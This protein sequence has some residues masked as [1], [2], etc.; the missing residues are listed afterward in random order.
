VGDGLPDEGGVR[1]LADMLGCRRRQVNEVRGNELG[2]HKLNFERFL[3]S[4]IKRASG[5]FSRDKRR[6]KWQASERLGPLT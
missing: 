1:H 6:P 4:G 2:S 5:Q 3:F